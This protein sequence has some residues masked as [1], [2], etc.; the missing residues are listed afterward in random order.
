MHSIS[1]PVGAIYDT[2]HGLTNGVVM[3]YVLSYN[4][5]AIGGRMDDL[6]NAL[7]LPDNGLDAVLDWLIGMRS[8]LHVPNTLADLGVG[9]ARID[10]LAEKAQRD[11]ST[12]GNPVAMTV[13]GFKTLIRAAIGGNLAVSA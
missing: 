4:R 2:H 6:A 5:A 8:Q 10:E 1:H 9:E 12:G 11:P 3:P 7:R 13:D